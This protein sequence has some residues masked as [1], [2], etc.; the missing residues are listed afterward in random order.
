MRLAL[1]LALA[2]VLVSPCAAQDLQVVMPPA[3]DVTPLPS[4][5]KVTPISL[6][7][8]AANLPRGKDWAEIFSYTPLGRRCYAGQM[9][10]WDPKLNRFDDPDFHRAFHQELAEAGFKVADNQDDLFG[11]G[12][13]SADLEVG[14]LIT[15]IRV[16]TCGFRKLVRGKLVSVGRQKGSAVMDVEWQIYSAA[17][18][19]TIAR[20]HTSGGWEVGFVD[21][22]ANELLQGAFA[23]N[24]R[25]L[26]ADPDF[27]RIVTSDAPTDMVPEPSA[28]IPVAYRS[29]SAPVPIED[30]AK[31]AVIVRVAGGFGSGVLISPDGYILTNH[32]V[33]GGSKRVRIRWPDGTETVGQ[34]IR[35]N[36]AR[37]VALIKAKEVKGDPLS[38]RRR[39]VKL[40]EAVYA[41]GTPL[42]RRLQNSVTRGVVS[43]ART[44]NG[45]SYIQSDTQVTHGDS[46]GPL[47]DEKGAVV[48]LTDW[49]VDPSKGG[50]L[51]FF[52]PIEDALKA[53]AVTPAA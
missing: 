40:G 13:A 11:E 36:A 21:Q 7:R 53:L 52:I 23:E 39:P 19:K 26:A 44:I 28:P 37:D 49:G 33:V 43:G 8:M 25:Q 46:G 38:I 32:H 34:L 35:S 29:A 30:A 17:E 14:A 16:T 5:A 51:N 15:D 27:R 48:G 18:A 42:D 45:H 50:A 41:I 31:G 10:T 24:V 47:L 6:A 20:I 2:L 1:G 12:D 22:A 9:V 3:A 4:D